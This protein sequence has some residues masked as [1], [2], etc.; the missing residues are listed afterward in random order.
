[1]LSATPTH[2][3]KDLLKRA[4]LLIAAVVALTAAPVREAAAEVPGSVREAPSRGVAAATDYDPYA[5]TGVTA[6]DFDT[7]LEYLD[8]DSG[9]LA[10]LRYVVFLLFSP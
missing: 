8:T 2:E 1:M 10:A 7:V 9:F 5:A 3:A 4:L 6:P